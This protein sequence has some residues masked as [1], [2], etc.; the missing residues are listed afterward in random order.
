M[1]ESAKPLSIWCVLDRKP[2][3]RTLARGMVAAIGAVRA[4]HVTD[5]SAASWAG[6]VGKC[7]QFLWPLG[8]GL[9]RR[10][11]VGQP[12]S[13]AKPDLIVSSGGNVLW[14]TA[15]LSRSIGVPA[16]FVGSRRHLPADAVSVFVHYDPPLAAEGTLCLPLLP[17]PTGRKEQQAA[18]LKFAGERGLH[19]VQ[20]HIVALIG[21]NGSGYI[22][23]ATEGAQLGRAMHT[24]HQATGLKWLVTTSRRTPADFEAALRAELPATTIADA[25]WFHA[26]DQRRVVASY[27]GGAAAIFV[28]EDSM[29]MIHEAVG[30]GQRVVTL[31]PAQAQ[32][33]AFFRNYIERAAK[34]RWL[35]SL[36]VAEAEVLDASKL[37]STDGG[38]SGD[39]LADVGRMLLAHL[40]RKSL[41]PS[42]TS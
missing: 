42:E 37:L 25:C 16:V 19:S 24:W 27:L 9:S 3:H 40:K 26:G 21:G 30:S 17:G 12:G 31:R 11:C 34:E 7:L 5:V 13:G 39:P 20:R 6:P 10:A 33:P 15:A 1:N 36:R 35:T 41:L 28:G 14:F 18:W 23:T 22:W 38:Y 32:P 8:A 4:I 2:G 29:S